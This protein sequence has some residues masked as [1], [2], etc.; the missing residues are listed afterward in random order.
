MAYLL[1]LTHKVSSADAAWKSGGLDNPVEHLS[2]W[3]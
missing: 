3:I 1:D 2:E